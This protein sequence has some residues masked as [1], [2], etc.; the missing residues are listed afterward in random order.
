MEKRENG[1]SREEFQEFL[2]KKILKSFFGDRKKRTIK[3][4]KNNMLLSCIAGILYIGIAV[5]L[6]I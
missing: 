6:F 4:T 2:K 1:Y 5:F 3:E